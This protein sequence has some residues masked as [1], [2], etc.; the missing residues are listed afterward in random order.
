LNESGGYDESEDS[1][2]IRGT[3]HSSV[4]KEGGREAEGLSPLSPYPLKIR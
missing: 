1:F 2:E 4:L 3:I